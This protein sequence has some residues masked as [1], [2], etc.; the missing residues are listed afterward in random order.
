MTKLFRTGFT[1]KGRLTTLHTSQQELQLISVMKLVAWLVKGF[2]DTL[3]VLFPMCDAKKK[4]AKYGVKN[5]PYSSKKSRHHCGI[6]P[7]KKGF[8]VLHRALTIVVL[9]V[10]TL[11]P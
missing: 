4:K 2:E 8:V 10:L 9:I 11:L 7:K 5:Y 6:L 3:K 1:P